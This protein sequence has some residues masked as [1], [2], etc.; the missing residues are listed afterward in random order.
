MS[1]FRTLLQEE[2][3]KRRPGKCWEV[4]KCDFSFPSFVPIQ[5]FSRGSLVH[6]DGDLSDKVLRPLY[7][8][9]LLLADASELKE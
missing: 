8:N 1:F 2:A 5:S 3:F 9:Q 6:T 7:Q 4:V